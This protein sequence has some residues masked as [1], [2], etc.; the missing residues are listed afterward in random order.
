VALAGTLDSTLLRGFHA[1]FLGIQFGP[2]DTIFTAAGVLILA[3]GLYA[4]GNMRGLSLPTGEKGAP[5]PEPV[6][7]PA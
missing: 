4:M 3:S 6:V 5:E 2:V 7:A 1:G